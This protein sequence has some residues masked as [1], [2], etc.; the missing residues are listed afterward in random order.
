MGSS[1]L[2][3]LW[4]PMRAICWCRSCSEGSQLSRGGM[5][6]VKVGKEKRCPW[7]WVFLGVFGVNHLSYYPGTEALLCQSTTRPKQ[8]TPQN[9]MS[10]S[11]S[12][13]SL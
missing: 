5:G 3:F 2:G 13:G 7:S 9:K 4:P 8:A 11:I 6:R 1:F 12:A 10:F